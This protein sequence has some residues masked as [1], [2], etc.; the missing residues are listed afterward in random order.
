MAL[1][2]PQAK[3]W[4]GQNFAKRKPIFL[5]TSCF[6]TAKSREAGQGAESSLKMSVILKSL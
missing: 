1:Q 2:N 5:S 3:F 4:C 6:Y